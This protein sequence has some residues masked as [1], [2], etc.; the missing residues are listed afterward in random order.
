MLDAGLIAMIVI[1]SIIGVVSL[2]YIIEEIILPL[3][4]Y[5]SCKIRLFDCIY[6]FTPKEFKSI[7]EKTFRDYKWE[8]HY[9]EDVK[10]PFLCDPCNSSVCLYQIHR[11]L[12][13][14][15]MDPLKRLIGFFFCCGCGLLKQKNQLNGNDEYILPVHQSSAQK[16]VESLVN[17]EEEKSRPS[18]VGNSKDSQE[19]K[20]SICPPSPAILTSPPRTPPM[21]TTTKNNSTN[22]H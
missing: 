5:I 22:D 15:F 19:N 21:S 2:P 10:K 17:E 3:I 6:Y 1:M 16:Q 9:I 11:F 12:S 14:V 4:F 7:P 13:R 8:I 18:S 20:S